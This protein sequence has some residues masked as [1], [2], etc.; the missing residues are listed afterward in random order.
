MKKLILFTCSLLSIQVL[1]SFSL[2]LNK[3]SNDFL[4]KQ[5][6][7]LK[8]VSYI[9]E[10]T[11][12]GQKIEPF[13]M[14]SNEVSNIDYREFIHHLQSNNKTTELTACEVDNNLWN[15]I[16]PNGNTVYSKK[17]SM[18][19]DYPVVNISKEAAILYCEWLSDVWN[20]KQDKYIVEFRLP[21]KDEWEYA[22]LGG[23]KLTNREYPWNGIYCRNEKGAFLAQHKAIGLSFGPSAINSFYPNEF[24]LYNISGNVAEMINNEVIVKGGSWNQTEEQ[25]KM[26][27]EMPYKKSPFVGFRPVMTLT[28]K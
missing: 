17:Y 8:S 7:D 9:P 28:E 5:M 20:N 27:S 10:G 12:N 3:K 15:E 24:G 16:D 18:M 14:F 19:D 2:T 25:I 22:A 13:F 26:Q 21:T 23:E 11:I 4:P 6:K 1:S